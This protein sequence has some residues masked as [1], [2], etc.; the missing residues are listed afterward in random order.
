MRLIGSSGGEND[1]ARR[2]R[3]QW[4]G[5]T[6]IARMGDADHPRQFAGFARKPSTNAFVSSQVGSRPEARTSS[7]LGAAASRSDRVGGARPPEAN[8]SPA[9]DRLRKW[10][11]RVAGCIPPSTSTSP[12]NCLAA[13]GNRVRGPR[14]G[15]SSCARCRRAAPSPTDRM[16]V[17]P[18]G[19]RRRRRIPPR[20]RRS[21]TWPGS[22]VPGRSAGRA[23]R[24]P[25]TPSNWPAEHPTGDRRR[26]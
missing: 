19:C 18:P 15:R 6:H 22:A 2:A 16:S 24:R 10:C 1:F 8:R 21:R 23:A 7:R 11:V 3:Q 12:S 25:M 20:A 17:S 5:I 9:P 13:P 26:T 14:R 4:C